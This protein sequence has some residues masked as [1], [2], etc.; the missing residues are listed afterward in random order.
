MYDSWDIVE[1][2]ILPYIISTEAAVASSNQVDLFGQS[3]M[4][5]FIDAPTSVPAEKP[6]I[7]S[8]SSEVDLFADA[9]FVSAPPQ[10]ETGAFADSTF[11]SAPPQTANG[12]SSQTQVRRSYD[13]ILAH[14]SCTPI[15]N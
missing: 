12:A 1:H 9:T 5:D 6:G 4:D 15:H 11:V 2:F 10:A 3:L 7:N 13:S 8:S 14:S